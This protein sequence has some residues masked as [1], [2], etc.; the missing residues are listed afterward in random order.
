MGLT[1]SVAI[2]ATEVLLREYLTMIII[3]TILGILL[4]ILF[5]V[6]KMIDHPF[7]TFWVNVVFWFSASFLISW[8][9]NKYIIVARQKNKIIRDKIKEIE[10]NCLGEIDKIRKYC[11]DMIALYNSKAEKQWSIIAYIEKEILSKEQHFNLRSN[12]E[13]AK[14]LKEIHNIIKEIQDKKYRNVI[15]V[16]S[17]SI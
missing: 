4:Q 1:E 5:P 14:L 12:P 13:C 10:D 2:K 16:G 3:S 8:I 17:N 15:E 11:K 9:I 6:Y 7:F